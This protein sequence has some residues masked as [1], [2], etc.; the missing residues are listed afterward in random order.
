MEGLFGIRF[1]SD[2]AG[3]LGQVTPTGERWVDWLGDPDVV[4]KR[5]EWPLRGILLD[6]E[7]DEFWPSDWGDRPS[8][9]SA[10]LRI[11]RQRL[12]SVPTLVPIFGHRYLPGAP[13]PDGSPVFSVY[14]TDVIYYGSDLA[15]YCS[16]EFLRESR[17]PVSDISVRVD[18]WSALAEG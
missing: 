2:H 9:L 13:A 8:E 12:E 17:G 15:D 3:L 14:Q 4:R 5:L 11:A 10:A 18:F 1:N 7:M 6:V 16:R